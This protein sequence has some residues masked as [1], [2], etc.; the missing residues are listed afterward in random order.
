M[1]LVCPSCAAEY[2]VMAAAIGARGRT[3]RCANCAHEWFQ[4]PAEDVEAT[5]PLAPEPAPEPAAEPDPEPRGEF[6]RPVSQ[7]LNEDAASSARVEDAVAIDAEID[8]PPIAAPAAEKQEEKTSEAASSPQ[9]ATIT[10]VTMP[11]FQSEQPAYADE[12]PQPAVYFDE[13]PARR[14]QDVVEATSVTSRIQ[15]DPNDLS[16]SLREPD[17]APRSVGGGAFL[18]GFA[19]VTFIALLMIAAYVKAPELAA[20]VPAAEGPIMA[21]AQM[22]DQGRVALAQATG[23]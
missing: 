16:A 11:E 3:V 5:P 7:V 1:R 9:E 2:E 15:P 20:M 14:E 23:G 6:A 8:E 10:R 19:T 12:P 21:Y 18:A 4:Q 13:D 17:E 22:V